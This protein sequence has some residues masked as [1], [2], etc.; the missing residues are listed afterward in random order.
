MSLLL[1]L[2]IFHTLFYSVFTVNFEHVIPGWVAI[3]N[4]V[5]TDCSFTFTCL[6]LVLILKSISFNYLIKFFVEEERGRSKNVEVK[7]FCLLNK[8]SLERYTEKNG[9]KG[10]KK[11]TCDTVIFGFVSPSTFQLAHI[12][13]VALYLLD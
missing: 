9:I 3:S 6:L 13:L 7:F 4:I 1:I 2:N 12:A 5:H 10:I 8:Q 11:Y